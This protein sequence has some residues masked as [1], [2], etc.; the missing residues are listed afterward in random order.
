MT[1][2]ADTNVA[3]F[4]SPEQQEAERDREQLMGSPDEALQAVIRNV[5]ERVREKQTSV[6]KLQ[7]EIAACYTELQEFGFDKKAVKHVFALLGMDASDRRIYDISAA[8]IR[9]ALQLDQQGD[10]FAAE[11]IKA[12]VREHQRT[13]G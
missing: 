11:K 3:Q 2:D 13:K 7:Q 5:Y 9:C 6:K 1:D 10:L 4:P 12:A 8:G